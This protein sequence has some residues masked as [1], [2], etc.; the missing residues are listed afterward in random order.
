LEL[1]GLVV[2]SLSF[3]ALHVDRGFV[4]LDVSALEQIA[5]KD[6]S[7]RKQQF[8]RGRDG[9][10][11]RAA[12]DF[13]PVVSLQIGCLPVDRQM[14]EVF[15]DEHIDDH[16]VRE[17]AFLHDL[18][19]SRRSRDNP[20]LRAFAAGQFLALDH[21]HEVAGRFHVENFLFL[22]ADAATLLSTA[23]AEPL[24]AFHGNDFLAS[25][26]MF[27]QG[28]APGMLALCESF[29]PGGHLGFL[30]DF[31]RMHSGFEL[32][33]FN[34]LLAKL[35]ALGP[36]LLEPLQTE[37]FPQQANLLL[38]PVGLLRPLCE[39]LDQRSRLPRQTLKI[40]AGNRCQR[41]L[42]ISC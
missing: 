8:A 40:D 4:G 10:I 25:R 38:E 28:V 12:R 23:H 37:H 24:L 19:A 31:L 20:A 21:S 7:Q 30:L 13:D 33:E 3:L 41:H 34:L 29:A 6:G 42:L 11:E 9:R 16:S 18:R 15:L 14:G 5:L 35:L 2:A 32:Q 39:R 1:I 36:V 22:V 27:G 26:Q 17:L